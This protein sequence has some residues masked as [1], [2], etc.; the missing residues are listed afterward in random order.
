MPQ[1]FKHNFKST[2]IEQIL[3]FQKALGQI[4]E[5]LK[6]KTRFDPAKRY[7]DSVEILD[8]I[9]ETNIELS[10]L[11]KEAQTNLETLKN[12]IYD[13]ART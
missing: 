9:M 4:F 8:R 12:K 10:N 11:L 1:P 7:V 13:P 5:H 2:D 3:G 6:A